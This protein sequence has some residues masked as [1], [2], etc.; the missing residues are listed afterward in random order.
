MYVYVYVYIYIYFPICL[1]VVHREY[2]YFFYTHRFNVS[3]Y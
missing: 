2:I 1:Q 3:I